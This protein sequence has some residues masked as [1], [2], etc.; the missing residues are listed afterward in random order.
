MKTVQEE[1]RKKVKRILTDPD[2]R[3]ALKEF[4]IDVEIADPEKDKEQ[5]TAV[6]LV[7]TYRSPEP[8][9]SDS[10]KMMVQHTRESGAIVYSGAPIQASVVHWSRNMLITEQLKSGKPWTH[11]VL[12]D[13]DMVLPA[14]GLTKLLAHKKDIIGGLCTRRADPPIPTIRH[15]DSDSGV[16][17]QIWEWPLNHTFEVGGIGTGFLVVTRYA[18]EQVAQAYFDCLW[19]K[20]FYHVSDEW[21]AQHR[22]RRLKHFDATKSAFWFRF[23]PAQSMA[24][25]QGEDMSFCMMASKYCG[26]SIWC[27]SSVQ[28]GHVGAYDFGIK[29]FLPYQKMCIEEAKQNGRYHAHR[30]EQSEAPEASFHV[31]YEE[32]VT[33]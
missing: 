29:D 16:F 17:E 1:W 26:L 27:D 22:E 24:I 7:P 11:A 23:L 32:P 20:D 33:Q 2:G 15:Y 30:V 8:Q 9:M 28:P 12:I 5:V 4:G 3:T 19:E 10:L 25:E 31:T 6:I 21:V 14:D 13:D 18:L